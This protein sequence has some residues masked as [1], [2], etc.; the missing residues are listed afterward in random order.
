[1]EEDLEEITK[2]WF[3]DLLILVD[4]AKI[5]NIDSLEAAQDTPGPRKIKKTDEVQYLSSASM[6]ISSMS[7]DQG[8]DGE[9]IDG[10]K[11]KQRK[12]EVT[13]P[14]DK[15]DPSKKKKVSP[16]ETFLPEDTKIPYN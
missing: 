14:R 3:I 2:E 4:P 13:P 10:T 7:P 1:M 12:G 16:L 6:K 11:S 15:E 8:G 5:S 9:E